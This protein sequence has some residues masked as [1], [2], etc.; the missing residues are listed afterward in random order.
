MVPGG[1]AELGIETT[2]QASALL[3]VGFLFMGTRH[4]LSTDMLLV[5]M[6]R[7]SSKKAERGG[8]DGGG[9]GG[10]IEDRE[11]YSLCA[12]IA[13]GLIHLGAGGDDGGSNGIDN[14]LEQLMGGTANAKR[15]K[16]LHYLYD[17]FNARTSA[18]SNYAGAS[19]PVSAYGINTGI[20]G[21]AGA[22]SQSTITGL[23][24]F[25]TSNIINP[26][27][28]RPTKEDGG[29]QHAQTVAEE[30]VSGKNHLR[31]AIHYFMPNFS[32][33]PDI[34]ESDFQDEE[35]AQGNSRVRD[36]QWVNTDMTAPGATLAFGLMYLKSDNA[37]AAKRLLLPTKPHLLDHIQPE[38]L[39]LRVVV[40][41]LILWK[42]IRAD[43]AFVRRQIPGFIADNFPFGHLI[44]HYGDDV[45]EKRE[46]KG[47]DEM[48][49][50][51]ITLAF[52]NIVTASCFAIGLKFAGT[53]SEAA[54]KLISHYLKE[55]V[56]RRKAKSFQSNA[57]NVDRYTMEA[58]L[59][60][61]GLALSMVMCG[62]GDLPTLRLLRQLRG[63]LD[64]AV[65]YG[66]H[67]TYAMCVG[68]LFLGG[69]KLTLGRS[70]LAVAA[71]LI[72][73]YPRFARHTLDN[74]FHLQMLRHF[75]VLAV[76][77]RHVTP[78]DVDTKM[79]LSI[80]LRIELTRNRTVTRTAPCLL[81]D[82]N[83]IR[84][85]KIENNAFWDISLT[86]LQTNA[87]GWRSIVQHG[88][89]YL[90]RRSGTDA[91]SEHQP[92][93]RHI[94]AVL[95]GHGGGDAHTT[96]E[97]VAATV[98]SDGGM[99]EFAAQ[100]C[101]ASTAMGRF[102]GYALREC[103]AK[104]KS[105]C[106]GTFLKLYAAMD[107]LGD[108]TAPWRQPRDA[109]LVWD[110]KLLSAYYGHGYG[111][112]W[113]HPSDDAQ[114]LIPAQFVAAL[115]HRFETQFRRCFADGD[116]E[117]TDL[118]RRYLRGGW[119][120]EMDATR[121]QALGAL[122]AFCECAPSL[123]I[124]NA[125]RSLLE[126]APNLRRT[127]NLAFVLGL[128]EGRV[129]GRESRRARSMPL[130]QPLLELAIR[131]EL[132]RIYAEFG[133][134]GHGDANQ[135]NPRTPSLS[136]LKLFAQTPMS[137]SKRGFARSSRKESRASGNLCA[138]KSFG[139]ALIADLLEK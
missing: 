46:F 95:A 81:P 83:D 122:L 68:F 108:A 49:Y 110:A 104:A 117:G 51:A 43:V 62:S 133:Q 134:D 136:G 72:A 35:G 30:L 75:Y 58:C 97:D 73:C 17:I 37:S 109:L 84:A 26:C 20:P 5:E 38:W 87:A 96:E 23:S 47:G 130:V 78:I 12:G 74:Q 39:F 40:R 13:L 65:T 120:T 34:N 14:R 124:R 8:D 1:F 24:V 113:A 69:G 82:L 114:P 28:A 2:V 105:E 101:S 77:R 32:D 90:K 91:Q 85:I 127:R 137:N 19:Q 44:R 33:F 118:L 103:A 27:V 52:L 42:G 106:L 63:C 131:G 21:G 89:I 132:Q 25:A 71:L 99:A 107:A 76:E 4:K 3:G 88:L 50:H 128:E 22:N 56:R 57:L 94:L 41:A 7:R 98:S 11:C 59:G 61:L 18:S 10:Q 9:N 16:M 121:V 55:F 86:A 53:H 79:P 125:L 115:Q 60:M 29:E 70:K 67:Q 48:D 138:P 111:A 80:P 100:F 135:Q 93:Q 112:D 123:V 126:T 119:S 36:G 15:C 116:G 64:A 92:A 66:Q 31:A 45:E 102:C 6:V 129:S 54:A 139:L